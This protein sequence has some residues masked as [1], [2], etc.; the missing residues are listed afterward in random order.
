MSD[1]SERM[2]VGLVCGRSVIVAFRPRGPR[3]KPEKPSGQQNSGTSETAQKEA[4][5]VVDPIVHHE[6]QRLA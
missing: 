5:V 3:L 2:V 6:D 1:L 4:T